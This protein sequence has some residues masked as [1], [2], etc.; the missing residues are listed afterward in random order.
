MLSSLSVQCTI[1]DIIYTTSFIA[2]TTAQQIIGSVHYRYRKMT[3]VSRIFLVNQNKQR[4]HYCRIPKRMTRLS[5]FFLISYSIILFE[6]IQLLNQSELLVL[7]K[8]DLLTKL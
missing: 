5:R 8:F 1:I 6:S 7:N 4:D 2:G 3:L